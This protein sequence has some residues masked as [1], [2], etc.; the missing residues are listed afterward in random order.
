MN[1]LSGSSAEPPGDWPAFLRTRGVSHVVLPRLDL[2]F[3]RDAR[4]FRLYPY[5]APAEG[6]TMGLVCEWHTENFFD[7]DS[8]PHLAIGLRGPTDEAPHNGRGLAIGV[9]A[10]RLCL[11]EDPDNPGTFIPTPH[12]GTGLGKLRITIND[13]VLQGEDLIYTGHTPD[14]LLT[15]TGGYLKIRGSAVSEA[16]MLA[17][18]LGPEI[19]CPYGYK[20]YSKA[21]YTVLTVPEPTT[22]TL[23]LLGLVS[24]ALIR[25]KKR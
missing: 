17:L 13:G 1:V 18:V 20:I 11:P 21:N 24:L 9:L 5:P 3:G 12:T 6:E 15:L 16:D 22:V 19:S 23:V 10:N 8:G 4:Q 7:V 25:R 14:S 2:G